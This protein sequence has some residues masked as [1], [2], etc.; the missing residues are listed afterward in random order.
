[1]AINVIEEFIKKRKIIKNRRSYSYYTTKQ[2]MIIFYILKWLIKVKYEEI[3]GHRNAFTKDQLY[4][5]VS[6]DT[7]NYMLSKNIRGWFDKVAYRAFDSVLIKID[8]LFIN[9]RQR[10]KVLGIVKGRRNTYILV[11]ISNLGIQLWNE[12]NRKEDKDGPENKV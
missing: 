1:M 8:G 9:M 6:K 11:E 7:N 3:D 10:G 12:W 4:N 2:K 5:Y